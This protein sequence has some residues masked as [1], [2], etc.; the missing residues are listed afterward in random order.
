[1]PKCQVRQQLHIYAYLNQEAEFTNH[2]IITFILCYTM[3]MMFFFVFVCV[4]IIMEMFFFFS[5]KQLLEF[6]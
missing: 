5:D 1:M 2:I 6:G 3:M 4:W